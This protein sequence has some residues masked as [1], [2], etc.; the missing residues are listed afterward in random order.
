MLNRSLL[1]FVTISAFVFGA[2]AAVSAQTATVVLLGAESTNAAARYEDIRTKLLSTGQFADVVSFPVTGQTPTLAFLQQFDAALVWSN[3][4]FQSG[5]A[6]GN[7]LADYVD[8]GGGVVVAVH[9]NIS[10]TTNRFLA[11]RW[12]QDYRILTQGCG[13][14]SGTAQQLGTVLVP[15]HPILAGV[16]TFAGVAGLGRPNCLTLEAHGEKV[17]LWGDGKTL[18]AI[19]TAKPGRVDLGSHPASTDSS[20]NNGWISTTDGALLFANALTYSMGSVAQPCYANCDGSTAHP[21]LN[22]D[23]FTCFVNEFAAAQSLP[24]AQQVGHYANC[25]GSSVAPV[26]N[27]DDFTCFINAFATGCP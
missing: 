21:V 23:D 15:G 19:S 24:P 10:T 22:V 13:N 18:V 3:G 27:V 25:D 1:R 6:L 11:G 4:N 26:L 20:A 5:E 8:L 14:A 9:A 16:N 17:A 2:G 7:V 12:D